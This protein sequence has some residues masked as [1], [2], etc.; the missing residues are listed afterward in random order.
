MI[1]TAVDAT[2]GAGLRALFLNCALKRS[3]EPSNTQAL[4]DASRHI[5]E[6]HGIHTCLDQ[7][8]DTAA[9]L[10]GDPCGGS[11]PRGSSRRCSTRSATSPLESAEG[12]GQIDRQEHTAP[13]GRGSHGRSTADSRRTAVAGHHRKDHLGSRRSSGVP[14]TKTKTRTRTRTKT[15]TEASST[16]RGTQTGRTGASAAPR[17][18][19]SP[20]RA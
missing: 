13:R 8:K 19:S 11:L 9:L 4:V 12:G 1:A 14:R 17:P 6:R 2:Y 5:M 3:P 18:R 15:R 7:M 16:G 20:Q 10:G